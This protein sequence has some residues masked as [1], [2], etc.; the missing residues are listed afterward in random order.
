MLAHAQ[1]ALASRIQQVAHLLIV[2]LH[3]ADLDGK[4]QV[5]RRLG[6]NEAEKLLA[7]ARNHAAVFLR[8]H[9]R[10]RLAGPCLAVRKDAHVVPAAGW[11]MLK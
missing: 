10:V 6:R 8:A 7:G 3:V 9:H 4:R 5:P 1:V 11:A 2:D